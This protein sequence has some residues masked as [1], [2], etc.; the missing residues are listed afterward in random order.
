MKRSK[1]VSRI[2]LMGMTP[3]T[4]TDIVC[5]FYCIPKEIIITGERKGAYIKAVHMIWYFSYI[6]TDVNCFLLAK[7]M[8]RNS[9]CDVVHAV[10]SVI[11]QIDTN[12]EYRNETE[13]IDIRILRK[14]SFKNF[15]PYLLMSLSK[16]IFSAPQ[17]LPS[18]QS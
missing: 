18:S 7:M 16:Q 14:S 15:L 10:N 1:K 17:P 9:H 13:K 6:H 8:G 3:E 5:D 11:N 2:P 4:I 12:K